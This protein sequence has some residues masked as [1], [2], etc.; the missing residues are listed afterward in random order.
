MTT[1]MYARAQNFSKTDQP[2]TRT[3]HHSS[4]SILDITSITLTSTWEGEILYTHIVY[5]NSLI[6]PSENL[7][8]YLLLKMDSQERGDRML[9]QSY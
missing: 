3:S 2:K 8:S 9:T 5:K 7:T 1:K 4:S 6:M